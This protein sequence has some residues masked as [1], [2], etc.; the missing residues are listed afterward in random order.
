MT[1]FHDQNGTVGTPAIL[2]PE[3][4]QSLWFLGAL[5]QIRAGAGATGGRL[6][7]VEHHAER[8]LGSPVHRHRVDDET[9]LVL[10]GELR[11]EVDGQ[12]RAAGT[13]AVAFLPRGLPHAFVVTSAQA[14][15]LTIHTPAGFDQFAIAAGTSVDQTSTALVGELPHDPAA[16][17]AMAAEY[18]I[19]ILGPPPTP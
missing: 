6:A 18:G 16:L 19:E 17:A 2:T 15:Y 4:Q 5:I 13:G 1:T 3:T 9:F 12:S 7:I 8:G 10:E 11:V 14:R